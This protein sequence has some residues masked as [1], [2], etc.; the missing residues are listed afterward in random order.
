MRPYV[1]TLPEGSDPD[2]YVRESGRERFLDY[3]H[4]HRTDF[5]SF[6]LKVAGFERNSG[7]PESDWDAIRTVLS[8]ISLIPNNVRQE[9]YLRLTADQTGMPEGTLR[10]ELRS[11]SRTSRRR[12]RSRP[13]KSGGGSRSTSQAEHTSKAEESV[14]RVSSTSKPLPAELHLL[15]LMLNHGER[16][17]GF[18][19]ANMSLDEFSEG[20]P[21]RRAEMLLEMYKKGEVDTN[22]LV[23][24]DVDDAIRGLAAGLLI[25]TTEPSPNWRSVYDIEVPPLDADAKRSAADAMR[26]LK[27]TR[28]DIAIADQN[29]KI[30]TAEKEGAS[31]TEHLRELQS[32]QALRKHVGEQE[33]VEWG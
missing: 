6:R 13:P 31:L 9:G 16:M 1:L 32:L 25:Q 17:I 8:S 20:S 10:T 29:R 26:R 23:S 3:A 28:V 12:S 30:F 33:F 27:L 15:R 14:D 18:I 19:L 11:M 4:R 24:G 7:D 21:R 22:D 2:S 5:V